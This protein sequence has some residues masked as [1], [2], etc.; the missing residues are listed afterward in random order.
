MKESINIYLADDHQI[1]IDGLSLLLKNEVDICIVGF[2]TNGLKAYNDIV[3]LKPDIALIDLRMPDMEGM[4][5]I[6]SLINKT[7]TKF[8]ILS[9]HQ[10][11][12]LLIDAMNYN[13]YA[14]L[15]KNVGQKEL[16]ET[17]YKV[18]NNE[19]VI[20]KNPLLK[21]QEKTFLSPREM[22]VLKLILQGKKTA[23]IAEMMNLSLFTVGT[24]RKNLMKKAGV[25]NAAE[26]FVWAE[27]HNLVQD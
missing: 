11:R 15:L 25:I 7:N 21:V 9:M 14:Y 4:E 12:R 5:I 1:V 27:K 24:H 22:D 17:I 6:K 26:L 8:I 2:A 16:L 23:Q 19:K 18:A 10:E 20:D 13:A 3:S